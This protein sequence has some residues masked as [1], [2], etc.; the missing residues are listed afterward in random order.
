MTSIKTFKVSPKNIA[1]LT[2]SE[3]KILPI[4]IDA[5]KLVDK[6]YTKQENSINNG[7]NFYPRDAIKSE[8][9]LSAQKTPK[10]FS[11]FTV[12]KRDQKG[13]LIPVDYHVEYK[14]DL[15]KISTLLKKAAKIS[16][17][18]S[19]KKYLNTL[20][21]VL[22]SGKY[23]LADKAWLETSGNNLDIVIG[24]HERYL[25]KLFFIKRAYQADVSIIDRDN[26]HKATVL[27]NILYTSVG[28]NVHRVIPPTALDVQVKE[29]FIFSGFLG[30]IIFT[31]QH[32]PAD[33][34]STEKYGS[35]IL[36]YK[37]SID[38][39]FNKLIY[40]IFKAIFEKSF[41]ERYTKELL[42]K[43]NYYL[44]LLYGLVQNLHRYRGSRTRLREFFP[45]YDEANAAASSIQHAKHLVLK[46]FI[47]QK[48]L[49]ALMITQICWIF[50][51]WIISRKTTIRKNYLDGDTLVLNF[52]RK[53]GALQER[54]GISWPNFA[55]MFFEMENLSAIFT[56]ILE[57]GTH[58]EAQE[59]LSRYLSTDPYENFSKRLSSIKPI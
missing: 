39:K 29:T 20:S 9:A 36:G 32:L 25:D 50:S 26:T 38:Y 59:F 8:I 30:K 43:G 7:A 48:E 19:F 53:Q 18:P 15:E 51:E 45:I 10:I 1:S 5:A 47:D 24:P 23:S 57:E 17:N 28:P 54:D 37:T 3:K 41:K 31:Q 33:T 58:I 35:R 42:Q 2:K 16:T 56:R 40:P 12:V 52:L 44:I 21:E 11:P 22:L 34:D 4:L 14:E 13:D 55:K 46:G 49:E 6:I 27:K